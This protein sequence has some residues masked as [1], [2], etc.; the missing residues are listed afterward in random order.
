[1]EI[2]EASEADYV[3][4][5]SL[6]YELY[7][8]R[9]VKKGNIP[10]N[11]IKINNKVFIAKIDSKVVGFIIATFIKYSSSS[12]GYLEELVITEKYRNKGFGRALVE[13]ALRWENTLGAEVVFVT[14]DEAQEFYKKL[15]FKD[16]NKNSW[17]CWIPEKV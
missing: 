1:M 16:M 8:E 13:T 3:N 12:A 10:F 11:G 9:Y 6:Y 2:T 5:T 7:P 14:T 4:I 15:G 17:L